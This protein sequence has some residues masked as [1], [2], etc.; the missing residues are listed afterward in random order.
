MLLMYPAPGDSAGSSTKIR[1]VI[2]DFGNVIAFFDH[3]RACNRLAALPGARLSPDEIHDFIFN[4]P[5]EGQIDR[6]EISGADFLKAVSDRLG[7]RAAP[8][9][10]ERA[11]CDIFWP[12]EA[13][14]SMIPKLRAKGYRLVLASNTN[15]LHYRWMRSEYSA[16]LQNFTK[17]IVSHEVG[18]WKPDTRFY[19][20]CVEAA[21]CAPSEC[22]YF[23]DREDLTST[24]RGLGIQSVT[25]H[26]SVDLPGVLGG[27]GISV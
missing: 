8:A 20:R 10:V 4:G 24:A 27:F 26:P 11:W 22:L 19:E 6:G 17:L 3:M 14:T 23:D 9:D 15:E 13:V 7:L 1:S 25:Y 21:A 5:L 18:F 2:F 12:N 16:V